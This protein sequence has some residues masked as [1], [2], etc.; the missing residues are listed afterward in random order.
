MISIYGDRSEMT[1]ESNNH[2][3]TFKYS[4]ADNI[5]KAFNY[6]VVENFIKNLYEDNI[7]SREV[8]DNDDFISDMLSEYERRKDPNVI[9][10]ILMDCFNT[11]NINDYE[12]ED[13]TK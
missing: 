13:I 7:I 5:E 2:R 1:I 8:M 11:L 9:Y 10:E 12:T 3:R 6:I 4:K